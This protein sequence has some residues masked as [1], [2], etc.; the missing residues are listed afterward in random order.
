MCH[1]RR[2]A[3]HP[4]RS[5]CTGPGVPSGKFPVLDLGKLPKSAFSYTHPALG[6]TRGRSLCPIL[7]SLALF[8]SCAQSLVLFCGHVASA[9]DAASSSLPPGRPHRPGPHSGPYTLGIAPTLHG[10]SAQAGPRSLLRV[11]PE[12]SF[13]EGNSLPRECC[14]QRVG[15]TSLQ[16]AQP[17]RFALGQQRG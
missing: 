11:W 10:I 9:H 8:S 12:T 3:P 16:R 4:L 17:V 7:S 2:E 15:G 6:C 1:P 5:P 14:H 13:L